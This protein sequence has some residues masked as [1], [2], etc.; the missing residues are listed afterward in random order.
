[1]SQVFPSTEVLTEVSAPQE[2]DLL[3][4]S[5]LN[6][7]Y[8]VHKVTETSNTLVSEIC[9]NSSC[10]YVNTAW[11]KLSNT[12]KYRQSATTHATAPPPLEFLRGALVTVSMH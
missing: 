3:T 2:V 5:K 11:E 8:N 4:S 7:R 10:I 6:T 9:M 12:I 1:M